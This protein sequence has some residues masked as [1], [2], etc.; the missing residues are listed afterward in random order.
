MN[1]IKL[2]IFA[3]LSDEISM[4]KATVQV[5]SRLKAGKT[6][7]IKGK[8]KSTPIIIVQ[9][10]IGK[11]AMKEACACA[12]S[13]YTFSHA[14]NI[15]YCGG[16]SPELLPGD[17][18]LPTDV[19]EDS[20]ERTFK[21][22]VSLFERANDVCKKNNFRFKEGRLVTC[23]NAIFSQHEKAFVGARF[24]AKGIDMEASA[25]LEAMDSSKVPAVVIKSLFDP[26][27]VDL[28]DLN[29]ADES[30]NTE[31][32]ELAKE[33]INKPKNIFKIPRLQYLVSKARSSLFDFID[34]WCQNA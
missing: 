5:D 21:S 6:I 32:I 22:D 2:A 23:D 29:V 14:I 10:G 25:F 24:V 8:Y 28:P 34:C 30:G 27:D 31:F 12:L 33:L 13:S 17:L 7:I 16:V 26:L 20:S 9:C 19:I 18:F 15:G 1:D 11:K 3:A 4:L